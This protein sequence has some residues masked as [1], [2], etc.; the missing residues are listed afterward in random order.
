M[1]NAVEFCECW[2]A[3]CKCKVEE[4]VIQKETQFC[5]RELRDPATTPDQWKTVIRRATQRYGKGH[6]ICQN[7]RISPK[8]TQEINSIDTLL[9]VEETFWNGLSSGVT[10]KV[11]M[12]WRALF[13]IYHDQMK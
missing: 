4:L 1:H 9:S 10:I 8:S 5:L 12:A 11:V 13:Y 2:S 3:R 6:A 7:F